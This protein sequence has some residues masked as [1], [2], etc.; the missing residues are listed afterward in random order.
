MTSY[1]DAAL[2][3]R[4]REDIVTFTPCIIFVSFIVMS[5]FSRQA[6]FNGFPFSCFC[7]CI[8]WAGLTRT[9]AG[10]T[11]GCIVVLLKEHST[12]HHHNLHVTMTDGTLLYSN[13]KR[14]CPWTKSWNY[15]A[16][17]FCERDVDWFLS[18]N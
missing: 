7:I 3:Q 15:L 9:L 4:Q 11:V 16:W 18:S 13:K 5:S 1:I 6:P 12:I 8:I 17:M 14:N 2:D 10:N